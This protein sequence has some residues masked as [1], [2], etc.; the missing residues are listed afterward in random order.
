MFDRKTTNGNFPPDP[1]VEASETT[2]DFVTRA[3]R[4]FF[5]IMLAVFVLNALLLVGA[6]LAFA[7]SNGGGGGGAGSGIQ[8]AIDKAAEW[9]SGIMT[10][11]GSLG[12]IA[13][14]GYKAIARTNE[15][16]HHAA[17]MGMAGSGVAI[18]AGLL[19]NDIVGLFSSFAGQ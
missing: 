11:L 4:W 16:M 18:V 14:I 19:M 5:T 15:N 1:A 3:A 10:S 8:G 2:N 13:S 7:Q 6:D 17:H 9:L 12:L